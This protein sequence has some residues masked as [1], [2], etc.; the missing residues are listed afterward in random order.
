MPSSHPTEELNQ[1]II[2]TAE[3]CLFLTNIG[4]MPY[5]HPTEEP[6]QN[7]IKKA[8]ETNVPTAFLFYPITVTNPDIYMVGISSNQQLNNSTT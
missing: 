8:A 6:N 4:G 7:I 1:N 3:Q 2:K 5:S